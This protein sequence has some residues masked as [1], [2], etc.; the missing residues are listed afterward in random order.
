MIAAALAQIGQQGRPLLLKEEPK[1]KRQKSDRRENRYESGRKKR[2]P[3][4]PS[5]VKVGMT[6]YRIQ[7]GRRDGVKPGN[8]V[9]A[10]ANEAGIDGEYIG[11]IQ[12]R[13]AYTTVD[14]PEGMPE[15]IYE[16][17][18]S[19]R[20]VGKPMRLSI[21]RRGERKPQRSIHRHKSRG[22]GPKS[23][24][25][26]QSFARSSSGPHTGKPQQSKSIKAKNEKRKAK[27]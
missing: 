22:Q 15:N 6:R 10:I 13:D 21:E 11:A 2:G 19:T 4:A 23:G 8:I 20:I 27:A 3:R 24:K 7:V 5:S 12:I 9:G 14:L 18:Q 26:K 25:R 16:S 17:L 1:P